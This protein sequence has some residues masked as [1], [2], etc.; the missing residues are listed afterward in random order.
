MV[1]V[2][3]GMVIHIDKQGVRR[4]REAISLKERNPLQ[5]RPPFTE[6]KK[7]LCTVG[8]SA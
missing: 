6:I 2:V 8:L 5:K 3:A 1:C 7:A 4:D